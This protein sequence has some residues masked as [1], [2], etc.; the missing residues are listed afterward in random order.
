MGVAEGDPGKAMPL[1]LQKILAGILTL[2]LN[3]LLG[4]V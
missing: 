4:G 3:Q 2:L 1:V